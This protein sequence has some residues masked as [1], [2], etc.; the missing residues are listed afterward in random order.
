MGVGVLSRL[1]A[2]STPCGSG[3]QTNNTFTILNE[4]SEDCLYL[5]VRNG[6]A[7]CPYDGTT[8]TDP[9]FGVSTPRCTPP[10]RLQAR[11]FPL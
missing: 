1:A 7:V 3:Y 2:D 8:H 5:N 11:T 9:R 10:T 6:C 4:V